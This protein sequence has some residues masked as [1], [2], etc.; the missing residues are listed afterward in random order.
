[1]YFP[2]TFVARGEL[3][4]LFS[5]LHAPYLLAPNAE[6]TS[7]RPSCA[8]STGTALLPFHGSLAPALL[9]REEKRRRE[10]EIRDIV[11]MKLEA[12]GEK[13]RFE[14][15]TMLAVATAANAHSSSAYD[16]PPG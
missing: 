13:D 6:R 14:F 7:V 12:S 8:F 9:C 1:M 15:S 10:A 11:S 5:C 16:S 4:V 3:T 2:V